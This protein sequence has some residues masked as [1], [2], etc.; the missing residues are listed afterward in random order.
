MLWNDGKIYGMPNESLQ[1]DK[2]PDLFKSGICGV[3]AAASIED[4]IQI[5]IHIEMKMNLNLYSV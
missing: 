4:F 2:F 1:R 3:K 5:M